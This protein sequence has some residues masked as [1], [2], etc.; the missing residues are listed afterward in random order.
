MN[1]KQIKEQFEYILGFKDDNLFNTLLKSSK[2]P[3]IPTGNLHLKSLYLKSKGRLPL[4]ASFIYKLNGLLEIPLTGI[5]N[6]LNK[7]GYCVVEGFLTSQEIEG[8][9][10]QLNDFTYYD[11][12]VGKAMLSLNEIRSGKGTNSTY[13][14][15]CRGNKITKESPIGNILFNSYMADIASSYFKSQAYMTSAVSFYTR[16]K[17]PKDF[18][19]NDI[20]GSAQSWH[21]DYA[22]IRFLKFFIYLTDVKKENGPH[23]FAVN[24]HEDKFIYPTKKDDFHK[25]GFRVYPNG[26]MEGLVKDEWV[27]GKTEIK[28]FC[29]P[30]GTLIIENTS[31]LHR[32]GYCY[33]GTREMI[34]FEYAVSQ[35]SK[36]EDQAV[37]ESNDKIH[38]KVLRGG[39]F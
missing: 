17:D 38:L 30:A 7:S 37:I 8:I 18:T 11:P 35:L 20:H 4:A 12:M 29:Y 32:G 28:E 36:V 16:A 24:T 21:F 2:K 25:A 5:V 19:D 6:D 3:Y 26:E 34:S 22:N 23:T 39:I 33:S 10:E 14:S 27:Q 9:K 13:S 15:N 1:T 31:G